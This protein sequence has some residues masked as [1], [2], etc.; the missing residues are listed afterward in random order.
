MITDR[1]PWEKDFDTTVIR[2][3]WL[4]FIPVTPHLEIYPKEISQNKGSCSKMFIPMY[5]YLQ[6][7]PQPTSPIIGYCL[8]KLWYVYFIKVIKNTNQT[9]SMK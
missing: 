5:L 2:K 8:S 1:V 7:L 4:S 9:F 3:Y 6:S